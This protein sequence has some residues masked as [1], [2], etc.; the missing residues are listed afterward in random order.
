MRLPPEVLSR[1]FIFH[2]QM[3]STWLNGAL[4]STHVC[5]QW[6]EIGRACPGLWSY[7]NYGHCRSA[8]WMAE[9]IRRSRAILLSFSIT[10][11]VDLKVDAQ[12]VVVVV[13]NMHRFE[14]LELG[15]PSGGD[16]TVFEVLSKPIPP[17]QHLTILNHGSAMF[18]FP[19]E[20][21]SGS[22]PNLRYMKII[23]DGYIPWDSGLFA[24][25]TSLN[26]TTA[27]VRADGDGNQPSLGILLSAL[28]RMPELETLIL[29][30]CLP[31]LTSSTTVNARVNLPKLKR[32][33]VVAPLTCCTCFLR[34]I[35]INHSAT[36]HLT[37]RCSKPSVS[38]E[39]VEELFA[40]FP[41]H[42]YTTS[43]PI[44]Q[45]L[46]FFWDDPHYF[47]VDIWTVQQNTELGTFQNASI[48]LIFDWRSIHSRGVRPLD[49]TW[50]CFAAFASPQLRSF[51]MSGGHIAGWDSEVWRR[52]ARVAPN[53][54]RIVAETEAQ[55]AELCK[56]LSPPD[57]PNPVPA[58]CCLPALSYLELEPTFNHLMP[59][60][61]GTESPLSVVFA[62]SLATRA[63]VGCSTPELA[64]SKT[65]QRDDCPEGWFDPFDAVP[66]LIMDMGQ[67]QTEP[68]MVRMAILL[69]F[70]PANP[71]LCEK[72]SSKLA[73]SA[74]HLEITALP[75]PRP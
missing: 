62:R 2:A 26:A 73:Q 28:A 47:E 46:K 36:V 20:F 8:A 38:R 9:M 35:T 14:S 69:V 58:D 53:V 72:L 75:L 25:L 48:K 23:T 24:H 63:L 6:W 67:W 66:G 27:R 13:D 21:L 5:K 10:R 11:Q 41:S 1:I 4:T 30:R 34:Q 59:N 42:L 31:P 40:V 3:E 51:H 12:K 39:D 33:K 56:A 16:N 32:L 7:I 57:M 19:P 44:A 55:C 22:A 61:D 52:L 17:L 37:I 71:P 60:Q 29:N 49:L 45:A 74:D 64:F 15:V 65:F 70:Y 68:L 43:T 18:A 54:Q 50:A